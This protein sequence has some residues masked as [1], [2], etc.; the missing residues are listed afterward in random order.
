MEFSKKDIEMYKGYS[1]MPKTVLFDRSLSLKAKGLFVFAFSLPDNWSHSKQYF[2]DKNK[3]GRDSVDSAVKELVNKK[4]LVIGD[5]SRDDAGLLGKTNYQ[6]YSRPD[7]TPEFEE[8]STDNKELRVRTESIPVAIMTNYHLRD[9]SLSLKAKGLL[10]VMFALPKDTQF[11][12]EKFLQMN[13]D[14]LSSVRSAL[15]EIKEAKYLKVERRR[16]EG[17]SY[18]QSVYTFYRMP[19]NLS[20]ESYTTTCE[21]PQLD[22]PRLDNQ[23]LD[24]PQQENPR[25]TNTKIIKTEDN[26]NSY[27]KQQ[28]KNKYG[29]YKNVYLLL[30]EYENLQSSYP[31]KFQKA[32]D[33]ASENISN[34]TKCGN[35]YEYIKGIA[36][37]INENHPE[38]KP[39]TTGN[40]NIPSYDLGLFY[41]EASKPIKYTRKS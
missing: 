19:Y 21:N 3:D 7:S 34:G 25:Q 37:K 11:S 1:Y 20:G 9:E 5:R 13:S 29:K 32:I 12:E 24:K 23:P 15:K 30:S 22:K 18:T 8:F 27:N 4:Y 17:G 40:E 38:Q 39:K 10:S 35:V 41:R 6:F 28:T 16:G 2:V 33:I 26:K 36:V 31:D 14:G